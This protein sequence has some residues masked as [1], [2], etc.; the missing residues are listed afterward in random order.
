M[1]YNESHVRFHGTACMDMKYF[2]EFFSD[3]VIVRAY[4]ES[5]YIVR[6]KSYALAYFLV[7][8]LLIIPLFY[9]KIYIESGI[10]TFE[11]FYSLVIVF[12]SSTISMALLKRGKFNAAAN[13]VI[14]SM[15][16]SL[17]V[18]LLFAMARYIITRDEAFLTWMINFRYLLPAMIVMAMM[19]CQNRW[20]IVTSIMLFI[21]AAAS[22]FILRFVYNVSNYEYISS[23]TYSFTAFF[24]ITI[25]SIFSR[26]I[27]DDAYEKLKKN[28]VNLEKTVE[29]RTR[30]LRSALDEKESINLALK[31][32][33][34]ELESLKD[35]AESL[36]RT[37][38][39]TGLNNRLAFME[40]S[41]REARRASRYARA[42]SLIMADI[43]LFK[44]INDAY[45][46]A[47]GDRALV[48]VAKSI[49]GALRANDYAARIGGEEFAIILPETGLDEAKRLAERIRLALEQNVSAGGKPVTCSFGVGT[50]DGSDD[51]FEQVMARADGALY[52]AK[53]R[54]RNRVETGS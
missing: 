4:R 6:Q 13:L 29:A 3:P 46:H 40:H 1:L 54:G 10:F 49:A 22:Y 38:I 16:S 26:K 43:D 33:S 9:Y 19:F 50:L 2:K 14:I 18:V 34:A 7:I 21:P 12:L 35:K 8:L 39:L 37:D 28:I 30:D 23:G 48:S 24:I 25:I 53:N 27:T 36:A 41:A 42:L 52:L 32:K 47:E 31:E 44:S 11:Y 45:G 17:V 51:S 15:L 5:P 20:I